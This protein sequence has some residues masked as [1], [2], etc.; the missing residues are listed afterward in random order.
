MLDGYLQQFEQKLGVTPYPITLNIELNPYSV[1][2]R[3]QL[4]AMK[5]I[6]IE[7]FKD[8]VRTFGSAKCF[9]VKIDGTI[10][11]HRSHICPK[12]ESL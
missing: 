3:K 7:G 1:N 8:G 9:N 2:T 6:H 4:D 11:L 10:M 5:D 12:R